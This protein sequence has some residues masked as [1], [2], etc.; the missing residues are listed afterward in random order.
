MRI[1]LFEEYLTENVDFFNRIAYRGEI[2]IGVFLRWMMKRVLLIWNYNH[3]HSH[4]WARNAYF[5]WGK[6]ASLNDL[7]LNHPDDKHVL[8]N[9]KWMEC[10]TYNF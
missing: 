6:I 3:Y 9:W 10:R 5:E 7:I 2:S 1:K 8:N 4:L